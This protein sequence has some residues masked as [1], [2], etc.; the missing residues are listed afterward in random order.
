MNN[1]VTLNS[2]LSVFPCFVV[3]RPPL[4]LPPFSSYHFG[5]SSVLRYPSS[6]VISLPTGTSGSIFGWWAA[7][8]LKHRVS[9]TCV[10]ECVCG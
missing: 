5:S 8:G 6:A 1:G 7:E 4:P 3:T 9:Q 10:C 2:S